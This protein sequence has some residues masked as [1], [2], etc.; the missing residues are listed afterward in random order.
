MKSVFSIVVA[1]LISFIFTKMNKIFYIFFTIIFFN[2]CANLVAPTGGEKDTESPTLLKV[3]PSNLQTNFNKSDIHFWFDE[4]VQFNKWEE[5]F[6]ISPPIE[7]DIKKQI[8]NKEVIITINDTLKVNTTHVFVLNNCVKDIN[9]GNVLENLNYILSTYN[10]IDTLKL[11]GKLQDAYTLENIEKAWIL[12]Y[13]IGLAD[14]LIFNSTPNYI[15]KSDKNGIFN[16]PNLN[17]QSYQLFALTEFNFIYNKGEKIAF[18]SRIVNAEKDSFIILNLFDP[19]INIDTIKAHSLA[20]KIDTLASDSTKNKVLRNG[21]LIIN[22]E[23]KSPFVFQL[24]QNKKVLHEFSFLGPPY[25]M[26]EIIPGKYWLKCIVDLNA[27]GKWNT[28]NLE[29]RQKP[30]KVINYVS[31]ITIRSNWD[32]EL[33]WDINLSE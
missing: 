15:A 3:T 23:I 10:H 4:Y 25:T 19:I 5:N 27:D 22:T 32:L 17:N 14:S 18:H 13:N 24:F 6:Y 33:L 29:L 8:K 1:L 7:K 12:L 9:E 30:E 26:T 11:S 2:S 16:F 28:G 20:V 21:K 31:E